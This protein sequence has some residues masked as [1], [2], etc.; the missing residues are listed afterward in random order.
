MACTEVIEPLVVEV[1]AL[2]RAHVGRQRRL[3][4]PP[5]EYGRA[6]PTLRTRLGEAEDVVDE[7]ECVLAFLIAEMLAMVRPRAQRARAPAVRSLA[8]H[9]RH[10]DPSESVAVGVLGDNPGVEKFV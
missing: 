2:Q 7:E 3:I 8:E 4:T 5:K 6:A 10:F 9:Q 1:M